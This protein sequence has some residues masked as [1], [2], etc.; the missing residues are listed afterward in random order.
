MSL[1]G[2][3]CFFLIQ[4]AFVRPNYESKTYFKCATVC[5]AGSPIIVKVKAY[6]AKYCDVEKNLPPW[7]QTAI[8]VEEQAPIRLRTFSGFV[9]CESKP[10]L[11]KVGKTSIRISSAQFVRE[12]DANI[13]CPCRNWHCFA[14]QPRRQCVIDIKDHKD[15]ER[16]R[17]M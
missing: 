12:Q 5:I 3:S 11:E 7:Y 8:A 17:T 1:L 16:R 2:S 4:S 9:F 10:R 14:P 6:E 13:E 15:F